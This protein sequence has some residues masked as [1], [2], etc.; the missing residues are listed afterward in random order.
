MSEFWATAL[1]MWLMAIG[2]C[3]AC[4]LSLFPVKQ[5]ILEIQNVHYGCY[6]DRFVKMPK[7]HR[8]LLPLAGQKKLVITIRNYLALTLQVKTIALTIKNDD[9][10]LANF[11]FD[12][13]ENPIAPYATQDI[14]VLS[15]TPV[16]AEKLKK[17]IRR[18][19]F[20]KNALGNR[21]FWKD[22]LILLPISIR[23]YLI[24]RN[25]Q[26]SFFTK[27]HIN[28]KKNIGTFHAIKFVKDYLMYGKK[29]LD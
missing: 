9:N 3:G 4:Y 24:A 20:Q 21:V 29:N 27:Q 1:P 19:L 5:D 12:N 23:V 25:L 28:V 11:T 10:P 6:K 14:R 16:E 8:T 2:T 17:A 26:I 13:S 15:M 7:N 22:I 18:K